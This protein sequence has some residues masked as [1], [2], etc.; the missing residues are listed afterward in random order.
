MR[1]A[2]SEEIPCRSCHE[3]YEGSDLDR[4]LWCLPCRSAMRRKA[5]FW[6]RSTGL[7]TSLAIGLYVAFSVQ[8]ARSRLTLY[9]LLV[10]ATYLLANRIA[11]ALVIGFYRARGGMK[12][13]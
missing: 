10:A 1:F 9:A 2:A 7:L 3:L 13:V 4:Y 6:A 5:A 11:M 8:P 12:T